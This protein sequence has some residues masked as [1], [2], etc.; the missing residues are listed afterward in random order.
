MESSL[1]ISPT[2]SYVEPYRKR[3][4]YT[5]T[6]TW[7]IVAFCTAFFSRVLDTLGA[8]SPVNF[9]HFLTVPLACGV[10]LTQ[11][12]IRSA[13]QSTI[14]FS[15]ISV[16]MV[17]LCCILF[18][19]I[20]NDA[21]IVNGILAFLLWVEPVL[22]LIAILCLP[23]QEAILGRLRK[24]I[25]YSLFFHTL[26]ALVQRHIFNLHYLRGKEDNIQGV[27][28][29][30]GAG[31]VVGA[32]VALVF[33]IYFFVTATNVKIQYRALFLAA[34]FWHMLIADAK[35]V[36][37]SLMIGAVLLL[38]TKFKDVTQA[39]KFTTLAVVF[40]L[41]FWWCMQNVPAFD[42]FNTWM[43]PEIYGPEGEAT[44]L[45]SATF[46]IIPTFY[47]SPL[48][49]FFGLGPGHTVDRLGGWML[50]E[51]SGLLMP[52]GAT[53]HPASR[54]IWFAVGSSWLGDQSS[55]FSP[56][57]GWAALWG[58]FGFI[59][60]A[61]YILMGITILFQVCVND[62]SKFMVFSVFA[63]GLVFSQ[64]QEPAYMLTVAALLGLNWHET[65]LKKKSGRPQSA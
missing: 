21:G 8:P 33:G 60:L 35:Q 49:W 15:L 62:V 65:N 9:L 56:L 2:G 5:R 61:A 37:L 25:T 4:G 24:C 36:L 53:V 10:A 27:F 46:R 51:Y 41:G 22:F 44:L 58:D 17:F 14:I 54:A 48:N 12:G 19:S 16:S 30:S 59:G 42:A 55:M 31:H 38:I 20:L 11:T 34:T 63:V 45:K 32:S 43:R 52:L 29:R 1:R 7:I 57:F 6:S 18:S 39:F 40:G 47:E 23:N 13:K 3:K 26:L 64:M 28:Y 50:R